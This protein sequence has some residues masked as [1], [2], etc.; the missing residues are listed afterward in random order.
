MPATKSIKKNRRVRSR[1]VRGGERNIFRTGIRSVLKPTKPIT[2]NNKTQIGNN[3][4][5]VGFSNKEYKAFIAS[6]NSKPVKPVEEYS[7]YY[8]NYYTRPEK[9]S[10][11]RKE[12]IR[13]Y[14]N[15]HP[16]E[17]INA[18]KEEIRRYYNNKTRKQ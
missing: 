5:V 17:L 6:K 13:K 4:P 2:Y 18:R 11:T 1:K 9:F 16:Q 7:E 14:Y 3:G 10:T 15:L 8:K 12:A